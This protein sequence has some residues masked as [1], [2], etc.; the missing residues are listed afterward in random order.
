MSAEKGSGKTRA[1]E[2]SE[3]LVPRGVR[4]SQATTGYV[5]AKISDVPPAT[6]FYDEIDTVYGSR[7][8]G[9]EDLRALLNAGHRRGA[10]AGRG[11]WE[12]GALE[13]QEYPAYCAVALAGLGTLPETVADRAVVIHMKK[14]KRTEPVEPWRERVNGPEATYLASRLNHWMN[15]AHLCFPAHMPVEDRAADVWEALVIVADAA[16]G[17]WPQR[18]RNAAVSST[19]GVE[20]AS[21]GVQLLEDLRIVFGGREKLSTEQILQ[22]LVALGG[23]GRWRY[24]HS[25]GEALNPRDLSKLLRPYRVKPVDVWVSGRNLKGYNA[26]DL[27]DPWER[28]LA[29]VEEREDR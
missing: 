4:V 20:K 5:L 23:E 1:L 29:P 27:Q 25:S 12:N 18:A 2:V 7:A 24:F 17:H 9:N 16:G 28:Y 19:D 21:I 26:D 3:L 14:R 6:L 10:T 22:E 15:D 13:G 8:R 11:T